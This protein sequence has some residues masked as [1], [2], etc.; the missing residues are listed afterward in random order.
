[1]KSPIYIILCLI[2]LVINEIALFENNFI[3][4][5]ST[6][7][8]LKILLLM[9][10]F[11]YK[12]I[13]ISRNYFLFITIIFLSDIMA[14]LAYF[15]SFDWGYGL[16]IFSF[17]TYIVLL[18][19]CWSKFK[20]GRFNVIALSYTLVMLL[21]AVLMIFQLK[22]LYESMDDQHLLFMGQIGYHITLLMTVAISVAYYLNSY[23]YKSMLFLM[24][25]LLFICSDI[26]AGAHYFYGIGNFILAF[27]SPMVAGGYFFFI[28]YFHIQEESLLTE[29]EIL[30]DIESR[31]KTKRP[32]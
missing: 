25:S 7:I 27:S 12:P 32:I 16:A 22:G 26:L 15:D 11:K 6:R 10:F 19:D 9:Y 23:S 21:N 3:I 18:F 5:N 17:L 13:A 2:C 4:Y 28:N 24:G 8:I 14:F 29:A 30:V 31:D 1:M 20:I